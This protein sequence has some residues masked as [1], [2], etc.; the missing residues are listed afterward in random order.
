M[1]STLFVLLIIGTGCEKDLLADMHDA[2]V[3][4]AQQV[5]V[6]GG[7]CM[8]PMTDAHPAAMHTLFVNFD[9]VLL[10]PCGTADARLNCTGLVSTETMIPPFMDGNPARDAFI[11]TILYP[12]RKA[13]A[14][15]SLDI[16]TTRPTSGDY[17]MMIYGGTPQLLGLPAANVGIA[18]FSCMPDNHNNIS[19]TFDRGQAPTNIDYADGILSDMGVFAGIPGTTVPGDCLCR[20]CQFPTDTVCTYGVDVPVSTDPAFSCGKTTVDEPAMLQDVL[21]CR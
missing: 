17:Y 19:F 20:S 4:D 21:G 9:G 11:A 18:P 8:S 15:Y 6:D 10:T 13:L 1:R 16:V 7:R 2:T 3:A 5:E 12:A 14:R